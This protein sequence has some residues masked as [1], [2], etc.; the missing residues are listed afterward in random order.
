MDMSFLGMFV[1]AGITIIGF[2]MT[3]YR[4]QK[5]EWKETVDQRKEQI[6]S[7][8]K[9]T[10]EIVKLGMTISHLSGDLVKQT[11]RISKHGQEIDD[12]RK[13]VQENKSNITNLKERL[14]EHKKEK[15]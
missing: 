12:L 14:D 1:T 10:E 5:T 7:T 15:H 8:H 2:Y 6:D 3:V 11:D 9:L 13:D 4:H